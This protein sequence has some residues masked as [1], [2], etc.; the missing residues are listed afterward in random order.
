M[1]IPDPSIYFARLIPHSS[2]IHYITGN[3]TALPVIF[4]MALMSMRPVQITLYCLVVICLLAV[5]KAVQCRNGHYR[6]MHPNDMVSILF[7][8]LSTLAGYLIGATIR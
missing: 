3:V 6:A 2:A 1:R 5:V 8:S 4:V 7:G